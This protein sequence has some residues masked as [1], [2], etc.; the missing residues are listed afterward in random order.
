MKVIPEEFFGYI[1]D[2]INN[3]LVTNE[4]IGGRL[5][6]NERVDPPEG[7]LCAWELG[8]RDQDDLDNIDEFVEDVFDLFCESVRSEFPLMKFKFE[9]R[10]HHAVGGIVITAGVYIYLLRSEVKK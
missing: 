7:A 10:G 5:F 2:K 8:I 6:F 4:Q 1:T 3:I 9:M